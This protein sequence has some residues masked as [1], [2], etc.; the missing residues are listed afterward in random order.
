MIQCKQTHM[1][2]ILVCFVKFSPFKV[3]WEQNFKNQNKVK[4][5]IFLNVQMWEMDC[6]VVGK[7]L[8]MI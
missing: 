5:R 6:G 8:F 3:I 2:E 4:F 1:M 7:A